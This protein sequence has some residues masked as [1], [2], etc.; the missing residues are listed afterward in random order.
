MLFHSTYRIPMPDVCPDR[1]R[2]YYQAKKMLPE[3]VFDSAKLENTPL[4]FPE[5]QTLMDGITIGGHRISDVE[6]VLNIRDAWQYVLDKAI[7]GEFAVN[8]ETFNAVHALI[9]RNEA[10]EWGKFRTGSVGI[11]GTTTYH[12]PPAE[13]LSAIFECE[14]PQIFPAANPVESAIR[15]FLWAVYN[16]FYWDGNKRVARI[17]A[18][19]LLISAGVGVF[20][21]RAADILEFNTKMIRFYDTGEA[22]EM[23]QFLSA[24]SIVTHK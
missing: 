4:T 17:M 19:G 10:L 13:E 1:R 7:R 14:L 22:D 9:S 5:V 16:Q 20:N 21:I 2:A 18:S 8:Q 12:A 6:T 24:K 3:Y 15:L 11:S 23:L